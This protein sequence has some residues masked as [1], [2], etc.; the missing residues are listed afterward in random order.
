MDYGR[1]TMDDGRWI[2][3]PADLVVVTKMRREYAVAG[4]RRQGKLGNV[5]FHS[6]ISCIR[7]KQAHFMPSQSCKTT[8][9]RQ[10]LIDSLGF[11]P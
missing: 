7:S 5:Y 11:S 3:P 8:T 10:H 9:H 6:N 4:E 1:W 2:P